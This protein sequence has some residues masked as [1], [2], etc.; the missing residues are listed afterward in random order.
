MI[1]QKVMMI[2]AG[3]HAKPEIRK[4]KKYILICQKHFRGSNQSKI[5]ERSLWITKGCAGTESPAGLF[6]MAGC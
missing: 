2:C 4:K 5:G 1:I 6:S 3:V